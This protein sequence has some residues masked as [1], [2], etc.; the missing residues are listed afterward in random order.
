MDRNRPLFDIH[1]TNETLNLLTDT[2]NMFIRNYNNNMSTLISEYNMN[3]RTILSLIENLINITRSDL[4]DTRTSPRRN[5]SYRRNVN[6]RRNN[7]TVPI[8][9]R[10]SLI[11]SED[12]QYIDRINDSIDNIQLLRERSTSIINDDDITIPRR[13]GPPERQTYVRRQI[14]REND[15]LRELVRNVR[16]AGNRT[17]IHDPISL[18]EDRYNNTRNRILTEDRTNI[19]QID[20]LSEL[21]TNQ[22]A[23]LQDVPVYPTNEQIEI[24][25]EDY[26]FDFNNNNT[27]ERCPI[28]MDT[29]EEGDELYRIKPCGH[30]FKKDALLTWFQTNVR[31]PVCRYDIR[32]YGVNHI[33][34]IGQDLSSNVINT[35]GSNLVRTTSNT[36]T[37]TPVF[38]ANLYSFDIPIIINGYDPSDN[39]L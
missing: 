10:S 34:E 15:L 9:R 26:I 39:I 29:F 4:N 24:A 27:N 25:T 21:I 33:S 35:I 23:N 32:E 31:C 1:D 16:Q 2:L 30:L 38:S 7:T 22:L 37:T 20:T 3:A 5:T 8:N 19:F 6:T 14:N 17:I 11:N 13:R 12:E 36:N 28:T 18:N